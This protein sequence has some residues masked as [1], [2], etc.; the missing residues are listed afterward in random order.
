MLRQL[1]HV[2][3]FDFML[4]GTLNQSGLISVVALSVSTEPLIPDYV[5]L[6]CHYENKFCISV[7]LQTAVFR[8]VSPYTY[9]V[10]NTSLEEPAASIFYAARKAASSTKTWENIDLAQCCYIWKAE[11]FVV[12]AF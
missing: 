2:T 3:T 12:T 6:Y 11:I 1:W 10:C 7:T 5:L 8:G 9:V 4:C